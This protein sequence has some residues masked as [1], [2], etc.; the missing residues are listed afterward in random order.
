MINFDDVLGENI[1]VYHPHSARILNHPYRILI[2]GSSG[3]G[4]IN[5]L[6]NLI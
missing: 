6:L 4:K 1:Q 2:V 3:S 5:E